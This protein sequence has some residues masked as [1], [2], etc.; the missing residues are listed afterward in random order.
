MP[1]YL[2]DAQSN[3]WDELLNDV[4]DHLSRFGKEDYRGRADYLLV[5]D[6]YGSN[7]ITIE[8][9]NLSMLNPTV[10]ASLR[11][12]LDNLPDWEIV[13]AVDV[14]GREAWPHMGLT[15]RKHEIIDG[16]QREFFPPEF[17]DFQYPDSRVGTG[18]D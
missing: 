13:V 12:L 8:A 15:I 11:K 2:D 17:R 18:Y 16:L 3:I 7:R 10:I 5:D 4:R 14:L 1:Q 9:Q 6:N